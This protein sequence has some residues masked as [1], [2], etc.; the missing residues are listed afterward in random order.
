MPVLPAP[1]E[2]KTHNLDGTCQGFG[3]RSGERKPRVAKLKSKSLLAHT[4]PA[5][6]YYPHRHRYSIMRDVKQRRYRNTC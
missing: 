1:S 6:E 5:I 3:A 2:F 4:M